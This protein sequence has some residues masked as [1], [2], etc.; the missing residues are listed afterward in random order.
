GYFSYYYVTG[1]ALENQANA[2]VMEKTDD[3]SGFFPRLREADENLT[4][5]NAAFL[6]SRPTTARG[7]ARPDDE[8]G[9]QRNYDVPRPDGTPGELTQFHEHPFVRILFKNSAKD[10]EITA[11]AVQEWHYEQRM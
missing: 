3:D 1:L 11:L 4:Q 10:A 9:M 6:L 2:F 5:L 7:S 8:K